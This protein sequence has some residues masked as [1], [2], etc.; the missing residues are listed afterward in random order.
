MDC[1]TLGR[2]SALTILIRNAEVFSYEKPV[3]ILIEGDRI[4]KVA[5]DFSFGADREIDAKGCLVLPTFVEPHVHLD[6]VLLSEEFGYSPSIGH[7]RGIIKKAKET[8]TVSSVKDRINRIIRLALKQGVTVIRSHVDI[9]CIVGLKSLQ[10]LNELRRD[11]SNYVAIQIV[12]NPQEGIFKQE[13]TEDLLAKSL[14][15]GVDVMGGL[16]EAEV[17]TEQ[18]KQHLHIVFSHATEGECRC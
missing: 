4:S 17:S 12:A 14:D 13:G 16:P 5:T 10:A 8:F 2:A 7:A 9:D 1:E 3:S 6:K 11:Y 15:S 18:S